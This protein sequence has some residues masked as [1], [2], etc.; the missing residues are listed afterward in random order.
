[1]LFRS[2]AVNGKSTQSASNVTAISFNIYEPYGF[3]FITK[4]KRANDALKKNPISFKL[5][6]INSPNKKNY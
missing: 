1:M 4:L 3:S 5:L 2:T 6:L